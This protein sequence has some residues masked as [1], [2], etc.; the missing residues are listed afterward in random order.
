MSFS[1]PRESGDEN[2]CGNECCSN[3][4]DCFLGSGAAARTTTRRIRRPWFPS[5][6]P[7][8]AGV[9][10][11]S[12]NGNQSHGRPKGRDCETAG[13]AAG[14]GR[15][16]AR[17]NFRNLSDEERQKAIAELRKRATEQA[18]KARTALAKTLEPKQVER[19]EQISL[20]AQGASSLTNPEV[21]GKLKLS[22]E[23]VAKL[24]A[25][26]NE[27]GPAVREAL[28]G[29]GGDARA[30]IAELRKERQEKSL[31]VLTA[32]QKEQFTAMKGEPFKLPAFGGRG[33]RR[34]NNNNNNNN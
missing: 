22:T 15:G 13:G 5:N 27:I 6:Q 2:V 18:K 11:R 33:S 29:G 26:S 21:A 19:L 25:I 10:R 7:V 24:E 9:D 3:V 14:R 32:E 16:G 17:P 30:K 8:D 23:Q 4:G 28:Q 20:Q 31:A 1:F 12:A 34:N